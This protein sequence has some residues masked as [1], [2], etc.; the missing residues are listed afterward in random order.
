MRKL[1]LHFSL[2]V[3]SVSYCKAQDTVVFKTG[4]KD[5]VTVVSFGKRNIRFLLDDTL[6][7]VNQSRVN[8]IK[9]RNG[10]TYS[11]KDLAAKFD[12]A[13]KVSNA[14]IEKHD[15]TAYPRIH[16]NVGVGGSSIET[17]ILN[18]D[19]N[20]IGLGPYFIS[21][22]LAYN[23]VIDYSI[24]KRIS[25]GIGGAYQWVNDNPSEEP[26]NSSVNSLETE[27]ISRY[28]ISGRILYHFLKHTTVDIYAGVRAGVSGWSEQIVSNSQAA[29]AILYKTTIPTSKQGSFQV[30]GGFMIPVYHCIGI[31]AELGVGTPYIIEAGITFR[32]INMKK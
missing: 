23:C 10:V 25:V 17:L 32:F 5:A 19:N 20:A 1:L 28:N 16:I 14:E 29:N 9:Y 22:S 12:S 24:N 11:F 4:E 15:S 8:Y 3:F 31:H 13:D 27:K 6:Y 30:L 18:N 21:Q 7:S 2:F 26:Q